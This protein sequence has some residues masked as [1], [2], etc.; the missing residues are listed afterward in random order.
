MEHE[1]FKQQ[2]AELV[3]GGIGDRLVARIALA[4]SALR[5]LFS[6]AGSVTKLAEITPNAVSWAW[7]GR[8]GVAESMWFSSEIFISRSSCSIDVIFISC[9]DYGCPPAASHAML[10]AER[11]PSQ[12][13]GHHAEAADASTETA[14]LTQLRERLATALTGEVS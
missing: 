13:T 8:G 1:P 7:S 4:S 10:L 9:R 6:G 2:R 14:T 12:R 11:E 5:V 3:D